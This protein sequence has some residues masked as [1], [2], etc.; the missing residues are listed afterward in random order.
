MKNNPSILDTTLRDGSY[1]ANFQISAQETAIIASQLNAAGIPFIEVGHGLGLGAFRN[2]KWQAAESDASYADA[3]SNVITSSKWGMFCIPEIANFD[4]MH[5]LKDYG[6]SFVRIGVNVDKIELSF[7]FIKVAKSLGFFVSVNLMKTYAVSELTV[8]NEARNLE[9]LGADLLCIVDSAGGMFPEEVASYCDAI[10]K[11]S[12][13]NFGFHGHNN[14]GFAS[15]NTMDAISH[16][17]SIVDTSVRGLGRSAGNAV[18]EIILL[19]MD[20]KGIKHNVDIKSILNLAEEFIDPYLLN[21]RQMDS[22]S[23]VSGYAKFHSGYMDVVNKKSEEY[24][25]DPR[26]IIMALLNENC[27]NVSENIADK[28]ASKLA[29]ND[30]IHINNP[31]VVIPSGDIKPETESQKLTSVLDSVGRKSRQYGRKSI[32]NLV[33]TYRKPDELWISHVIHDDRDFVLASGEVGSAKQAKMISEKI[34]GRVDY[35]FLDIDYKNVDSKKII[36]QVESIL[37]KSKLLKYSDL[38]VWANSIL[39]LALTISNKNTCEVS[40]CG[41]GLLAESIINMAQ[42]LSINIVDK[43]N[44]LIVADFNCDI[45]FQSYDIVI[46]GIIGGI[47]NERLQL[48]HASKIRI[49]RPDMKSCIFGEVRAAIGIFDNVNKTQGVAKIG[50]HMVAAGGIVVPDGYVIVDSICHPTCAIGIADGYGQVK[51]EN[52]LTQI[53]QKIL[54]EVEENI[55][56]K[57]LSK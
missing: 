24:G 27:I 14:L 17:A 19:A 44:I 7:P 53:E 33:Q 56:G 6:A 31:K 28:V 50:T 8:V 11:G 55:L 49:Y 23:I 54:R 5:I 40:I 39:R 51:S 45:D 12:N 57:R 21:Y 15:A 42:V 47:S 2:P 38:Y 10:R 25:V 22:I 34:D 4:D 32:F 52:I 1:V 41:D 3:A 26:K 48:M 29:A 20:R 16:G 13:M 30:K 9:T 43:S 18:T 37:K 36:N 46:D 35:V